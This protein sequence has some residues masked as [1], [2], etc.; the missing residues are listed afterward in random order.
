MGRR[1]SA[2]NVEIRPWLSAK[3][4]GKEGRFIQIGNSFLLEFRKEPLN[5]LSLGARWMYL[6]MT[7]ESAGHRDFTFVRFVP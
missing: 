5:K 6:C 3:A 2:R 4:D 7:M 1:K